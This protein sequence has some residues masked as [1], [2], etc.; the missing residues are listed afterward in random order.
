M[1]C[2]PIFGAL[3]QAMNNLT[4]MSAWRAGLD[5]IEAAA[6]AVNMPLPLDNA[7]TLPACPRL[8]IRVN[9]VFAAILT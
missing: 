9:A 3:T 4:P 7:N 2:R 5:E 1:F 8:G 6:R